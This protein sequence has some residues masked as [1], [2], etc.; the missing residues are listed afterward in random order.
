MKSIE[1]NDSVSID[2]ENANEGDR[3]SIIRVDKTRFDGFVLNNTGSTLKI[4]RDMHSR[5]YDVNEIKY[6]DILI[7]QRY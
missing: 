7:V 1:K 6:D 3:V 5:G 2:P 4:G